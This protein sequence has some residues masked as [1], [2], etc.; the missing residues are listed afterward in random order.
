MGRI[1]RDYTKVGE[2]RLDAWTPASFGITD[3]SDTTWAVMLNHSR[4]TD[5][6][7]LEKALS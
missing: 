6:R 3:Y 2:A 4:F 1:S 7:A 5:H